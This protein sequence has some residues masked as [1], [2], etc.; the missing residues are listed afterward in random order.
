MSLGGCPENK[1]M[2]LCP[3]SAS[4]TP[5]F[6]SS[7]WSFSD[8]GDHPNTIAAEDTVTSPAKLLNLPFTV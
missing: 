3:L 4:P 7:T 5:D 1:H 6:I 2:C 8:Q